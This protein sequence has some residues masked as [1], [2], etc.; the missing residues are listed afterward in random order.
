MARVGEC[1]PWERGTC[2]QCGLR[3]EPSEAT[4]HLLQV[5]RMIRAGARLDEDALSW[6]AWQVIGYLADLREHEARAIAMM[7]GAA[8]G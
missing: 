1:G 7:G 8:G 5:D 6:E 3:K 2:K 4:Q